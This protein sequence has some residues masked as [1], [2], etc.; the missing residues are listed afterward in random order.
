MTE[1]PKQEPFHA[2]RL[3][4]L[5][6]KSCAANEIGVEAC[7]LVTC[8][9]MVEDAKRYSGPVTFWT[10][11]LLPISGFQSWGRLDRSRKRAVEAGWLHYAAGTNRQCARYWTLI[12]AP[13][14][15]AFDDSPVDELDHQTED[16]SGI[17]H[18]NRAPDGDDSEIETKTWRKSKRKSSIPKPIPIPKELQSPDFV[19]VWDQWIQHRQEIRKPL[20]PTSTSQQLNKLVCWGPSRA[21]AALQHTIA[22]GWQGIREPEA[23]NGSSQDDDWQ[24]VREVIQ[25]TYHPDLKN[26]ADVERLLTQTQFAAAVSVGLDRIAASHP[27][28]RATMEAYRIARKAG[29]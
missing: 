23:T 22:N 5:L 1:Y 26:R 16:S 10:G 3:I 18:Q 20:T 12:P 14:K 15:A 6:Q 2:L 27:A 11:Q 25:G 19:T 7:W 24:T 13:I 28:D 8:I 29:S 17:N 21:I 4:R 9:A